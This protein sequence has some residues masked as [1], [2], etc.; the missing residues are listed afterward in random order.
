MA[1]QKDLAP[2]IKKRAYSKNLSDKLKDGKP[3][4]FPMEIDNDIALK[5]SE[6]KESSPNGAQYN[7]IINNRLR[8]AYGL[9]VKK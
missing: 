1:K 8:K 3:W 9:K 6:E 4:K 7:K 2:V 5:V